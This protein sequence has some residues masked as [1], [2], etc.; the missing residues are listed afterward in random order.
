M[1]PGLE[2][3]QLRHAD[4]GDGVEPK[5]GLKV[6]IAAWLCW[7]VNSFLLSM[8]HEML[9]PTLAKILHQGVTKGGAALFLGTIYIAVRGLISFFR[10]KPSIKTSDP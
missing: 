3:P 8:T 9:N 6:V 5:L 4:T 10:R 7:I 2:P 1:A